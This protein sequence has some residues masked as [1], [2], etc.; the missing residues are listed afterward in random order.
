MRRRWRS[1]VAFCV[2]DWILYDLGYAEEMDGV[3]S[4]SE[5]AVDS[6]LYAGKS[7][8]PLRRRTRISLGYHRYYHLT[9]SFDKNKIRSVKSVH[10]TTLFL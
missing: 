7:Y 6:W 1:G 3:D 5:R 2:N 8:G 10:T 9:G 4:I